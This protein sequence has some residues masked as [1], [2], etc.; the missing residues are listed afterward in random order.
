MGG[1]YWYPDGCGVDERQRECAAVGDAVASLLDASAFA[2]RRKILIGFSQGGYLSYRLVKAHP[3]LFDAAILLSP[4]FMGE[5]QGRRL[6]PLP[7]SSWRMARRTARFRCPTSKR[8]IRSLNG[9][10][11]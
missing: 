5:E 10:G 4:S 2:H 7:D 1:N 11:I 8:P 9:P 6:T 3:T